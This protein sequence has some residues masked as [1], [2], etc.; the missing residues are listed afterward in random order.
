[1]KARVQ[2]TA[3]A[4]IGSVVRAVPSIG[5]RGLY[6]CAAQVPGS[7]PVMLPLLG[8][9]A[10]RAHRG[11]ACSLSPSKYPHRGALRGDDQPEN[12]HAPCCTDAGVRSRQHCSVVL[13]AL[14]RLNILPLL[15]PQGLGSMHMMPSCWTI[16]RRPCMLALVPRLAASCLVPPCGC[17]QCWVSPQRT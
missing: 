7:A 16:W 2:A 6:W 15:L 14:H 5:L 4:S 11:A 12:L 10:A 1:M 9:L 8:A 17:L 13:T 3:G